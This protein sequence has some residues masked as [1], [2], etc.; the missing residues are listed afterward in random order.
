[1]ETSVEK[2]NRLLVR[3]TAVQIYFVALALVA[4][5]TLVDIEVGYEIAV[6]IFFLIPIAV[7]T[8]YRS[9]LGGLVFCVISSLV[10][11]LVDNVFSAHPYLNPVAPYWNA[12]V[13]AGFFLVTVELLNQLKI[14]LYIE[15][16]LA[17]TDGLTGLLNRRAFTEQVSRLF[18]VAGRHGRP[19]VL[20]YIDLDNF[21]KVND[22]HGHSEG[23]RVLQVVASEILK[24]LRTT[25]VAA[26]MGGDEFAI[27][28]P[29]TDEGGAKFVFDNLMSTILKE[30]Q[31]QNW[32]IGLSVGVVS[33]ESPAAGLDD[34]IR[35]ADGL[36]YQVK[37]GGKNNILFKHQPRM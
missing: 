30:T 15:Q 6:S 34:A 23:D 21:K 14:H 26:R 12:A 25:D 20:A 27:V 8:W 4:A 35:I 24:S 19:V 5:I 16:T 10:W 37:A 18:S 29:E 28:L 11:F 36:M 22:E 13:R 17:R 2:F 1:M 7:V 33:F 31:K 3:A 32:P 9:Y